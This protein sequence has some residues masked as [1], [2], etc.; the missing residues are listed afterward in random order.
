MA[1]KPFLR[2]DASNW[3]MNMDAIATMFN[4]AT[5]KTAKSKRI[6]DDFASWYNGIGWYD[7]YIDSQVTLDK[8]LNFKNRYW[9]ADAVTKKEK[10]AAERV[11][12]TGLTQAE[13]MGHRVRA[14]TAEGYIAEPDEGFLTKKGKIALGLAI[15]A[16]AGGWLYFGGGLVAVATLRNKLKGRREEQEQELKALKGREKMHP[17]VKE[18]FPHSTEEAEMYLR[19]AIAIYPE[20]SGGGKSTVDSQIQRTEY[21]KSPEQY[22]SRAKKTWETAKGLRDIPDYIPGTSPPPRWAE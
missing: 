3:E 5:P 21:S 13:T 7:K 22:L 1:D 9:A 6:K 8:A 14:K 18:Q 19:E 12:R 2:K 4:K 10:K 15:L 16:G 11:R 17:S 20:L